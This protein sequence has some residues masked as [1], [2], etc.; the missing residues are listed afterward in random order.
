MTIER[1]AASDGAERHHVTE[2]GDKVAF[3][4]IEAAAYLGISTDTLDRMRA[5]GVIEAFR[6]GRRLVRFRKS[7][8]D[9]FMSRECISSEPRTL[10]TGMCNGRKMAVRNAAALG[11]Q[12]VAKLRHSSRSSS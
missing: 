7:E 4:R 12:A 8:L 1:L 3:S 11:R 2:P 6:A 5:A 10:P 9:A